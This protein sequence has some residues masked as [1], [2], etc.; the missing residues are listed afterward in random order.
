MDWIYPA[1][2]R[3]PVKC[4]ELFNH[5]AELQLFKNRSALTLIFINE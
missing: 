1:Y 5:A 3:T 2:I 4:R